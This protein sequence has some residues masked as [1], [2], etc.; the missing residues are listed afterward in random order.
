M[1]ETE[2]EGAEKVVLGKFETAAGEVLGDT[3]MRVRGEARQV[4]GHIQEAAGAV[5]ETLEHA[6]ERAKAA[7]ATAGD[8]YGRVSGAARG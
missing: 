3:G 1:N 8:A 7:L 5:Q 2:A 6:A 4:G